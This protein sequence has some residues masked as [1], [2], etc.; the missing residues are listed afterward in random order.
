MSEDHKERSPDLGQEIRASEGVDALPGRLDRYGKAKNRA[1][2]VAEYI[3]QHLA[4]EGPLARRVGACGE[5]LLFRHY[6]TADLLRLHAASFCMKHLLCPLCAIRRGAK[7][8]KAYLD[9]WEVIQQDRPALRPFLV[10]LTVK[11]GDNLAERFRHLHESQRALW[12][13]KHRGR[14][15]VL[16][17]VAGAVWSYEVKRGA[18]SGLW[19][20]HLHMIALAE[21][22]PSQERLSR[23]W[24]AVTGD[25]HVVDVRPISQEDPASGF[26]EVFKYAVKASDMELADTVHAHQT[27]KGKRL[28]ASAGCFRGVEV[29]EELTDDP[30]EGLPFVELLFR[31]LGGQY[32]PINRATR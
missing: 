29:P 2:D 28:I 9:R 32:R 13:R 3:G 16:D 26:I 5:Y 25:S 12:M 7:A 6:Y 27:L 1:V 4:G 18:G 19:H 15:C 17:G 8:L 14:G 22:E 21:V 30:L 20:P 11:D 31:H 10:T 23:E 24:H